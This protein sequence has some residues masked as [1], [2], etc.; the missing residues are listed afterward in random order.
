MVYMVYFQTV[1]IHVYA[2]I[3]CVRNIVKFTQKKG[4]KLDIMVE[5]HVDV[6]KVASVRS[7]SIMLCSTYD[8]G[9]QE[10]N[11]IHEICTPL[12]SALIALYR[13]FHRNY[14]IC[15]FLKVFVYFLK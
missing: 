2:V 10:I 3:S 8:A 5:F 6:Y 12:Y 4:V 9:Y 13:Y 11:K 1:Y 15:I 14:I 7:A